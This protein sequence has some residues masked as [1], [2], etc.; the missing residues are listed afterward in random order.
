MEG[1]H[2]SSISILI[3]SN[4]SL[5]QALT[6]DQITLIIAEPEPDSTVPPKMT[7]AIFN[8]VGNAI[9]LRFSGPTNTPSLSQINQNVDGYLHRQSYQ[10]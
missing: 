8:Q 1:R 2:R 10:H 4:D 6:L 7:E 9:N 3:E 5:Y